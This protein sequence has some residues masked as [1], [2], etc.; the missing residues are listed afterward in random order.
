MFDFKCRQCGQILTLLDHKC[1]PEEWAAIAKYLV[2]KHLNASFHGSLKH[3]L[4]ETSYEVIVHYGIDKK[5]L[6]TYEDGY[7]KIGS[8]VLDIQDPQLLEKL[9]NIIDKH[10]PGLSWVFSLYDKIM[11]ISPVYMFVLIY[12][13]G[14]VAIFVHEK[15]L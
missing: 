11:P 15:L 12:F 1:N 6:I 14:C 9:D 7:V 5:L 10:E 4:P 13:I 2:N 3:A 8:T